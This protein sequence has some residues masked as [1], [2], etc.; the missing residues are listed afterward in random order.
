MNAK[1][2]YEIK[3]AFKLDGYKI[4]PHNYSIKNSEDNV[5]ILSLNFLKMLLLNAKNKNQEYTK[6]NIDIKF[7]LYTTKKI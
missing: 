7:K 3:F 6:P 1:Q 2:I 4:I 5:D